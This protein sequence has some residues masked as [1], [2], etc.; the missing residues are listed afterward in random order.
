MD[1]S[2]GYAHSQVALPDSVRALVE[3]RDWAALDRAI[4]AETKPGGLIFDQLRPLAEF[5][6]IEFILSIRCS[7]AHPD[8]DGIWHD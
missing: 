1:L 7:D 4:A 8:E 6:E 5:T 2:R 3:K